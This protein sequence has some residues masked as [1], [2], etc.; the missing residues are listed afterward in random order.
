LIYLL[1]LSGSAASVRTAE[2]KGQQNGS[3]EGKMNIWNAEK[4]YNQK[5]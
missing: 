4:K 1:K 5:R 2:I 3:A